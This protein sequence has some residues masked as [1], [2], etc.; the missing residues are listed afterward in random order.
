MP[1]PELMGKASKKVRHHRA[2]TW[3][4]VPAPKNPIHNELDGPTHGDEDS[5]IIDGLDIAEVETSS[6]DTDT[7]DAAL[8]ARGARK[9]GVQNEPS[10]SSKDP[11][12][13]NRRRNEYFTPHR[14]REVR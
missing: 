7:S 14:Q 6:V 10:R 9:N 11:P 1:L 5:S 12:P 2:P 8:T 4:I 3:A 13:R